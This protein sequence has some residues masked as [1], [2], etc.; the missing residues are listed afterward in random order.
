MSQEKF[1]RLFPGLNDKQVLYSIF[2]A[3]D[4]LISLDST[5]DFEEFVKGLSTMCRGN[6]KDKAECTLTSCLT[7]NNVPDLMLL[8]QLRMKFSIWTMTALLTER[9]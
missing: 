7:V 3:F 2:H 8:T 1:L 4:R 5:I 6:V 9:K